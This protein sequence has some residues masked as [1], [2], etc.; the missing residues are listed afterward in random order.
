MDYLNAVQCSGLKPIVSCQ[1]NLGDDSVDGK[2]PVHP[3]QVF[4]V[5]APEGV[6]EVINTRTKEWFIPADVDVPSTNHYSLNINRRVWDWREGGREGGREGVR[7]EG[8]AIQGIIH[9]YPSVVA[10][11]RINIL[12]TSF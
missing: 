2:I 12:P 7:E 8:R 9:I 5:V 10:N 11:A 6:D 1:V 4:W 3:H